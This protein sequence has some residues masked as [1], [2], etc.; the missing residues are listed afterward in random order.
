LRFDGNWTLKPRDVSALTRLAGKTLERD[1]N[2]Q[3]VGTQRDWT[4]WTDAPVLMFSSDEAPASLTEADLIKLRNYMLAGGTLFTHADNGS[5]KFN[6]YVADI[7]RRIFPDYK[8]E[9]LSDDHPIY[10]V[11]FPVTT[12]PKLLA[13]SNGSRLLWV[14]SPTDLSKEWTGKPDK[15][16]SYAAETATN[17]AVYS[18][19]KRDLRNR[20]ATGYVAER[21]D[22]PI[23]TVP[24]ARLAYDGNWNPEPWG[25]VRTARKFDHETSIGLDLRG[26]QVSQL[27]PTVAPLAHLTGTAAVEFSD[28][29]IQALRTYVADGGILLIDACGGSEPFDRS[30]RQK[31]LP[32]A[33][34]EASLKPVPDSHPLM[35]GV[36]R[37]RTRGGGNDSHGLELL[38]FGR[39]AVILSDLDL[40]SGLVG[41]QSVSIRGYEPQTADR[42][43]R[44]V[45][46]WSIWPTGMP[47][48]LAGAGN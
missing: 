29:E 46:A 30:I 33:F 41:S 35:D 5:A 23:A 14:H 43:V 19:G 47:R 12:K 40:S 24:V 6:A 4:D 38:A 9:E 2:W 18:M 26:V 34:A 11:L 1:L 20:L 44:N 17:I 7:A 8:L 48:M 25:W 42:I 21:S 16:K 3:V 37:T 39:G 10:S 27:S 22:P 15:T 13:V 32:K 36:D 28:A 31:L 45:I